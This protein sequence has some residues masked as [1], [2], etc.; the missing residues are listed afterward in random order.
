MSALT[1]YRLDFDRLGPITVGM[2]REQAER[3]GGVPL[4]E[5]R[6]YPDGECSQFFAADGRG[7][8]FLAIRGR[9]ATIED[10]RPVVTVDGLGAG[11]TR[12]EVVH[13]YGEGRV[14]ERVNRFQVREIAVTRDGARGDYGIVFRFTPGGDAVDRVLVGRSSELRRDEGCF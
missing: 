14:D 4:N 8:E 6:P 2:T 5:D 9:V 12:D 10:G 3:A 7:V 13:T 1:R 11:A